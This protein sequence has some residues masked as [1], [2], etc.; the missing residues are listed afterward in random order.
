MYNAFKRHPTEPAEAGSKYEPEYSIEIS[1]K[2]K[3]ELV[4]TGET[5]TYDLIQESY[6]STKIENIIRRATLGDTTALEARA[7][8]YIDITNAPTS[9]AE[10]QNLLIKTKEEFDKLPLEV[11]KKFDMSPEMYVNEYMTDTWAEKMGL[12]ENTAVEVEKPVVKE[13]VVNE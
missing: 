11:R 6:E 5:C 4:K 9:L 8:Q 1:K 2:G 10:M 12:K 7:G 13:E 3:K